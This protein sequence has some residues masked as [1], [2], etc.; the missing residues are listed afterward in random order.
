MLVGSSLA[1]IGSG[2]AYGFYA[3]A[4]SKPNPEDYIAP[5]IIAG[6]IGGLAIIVGGKTAIKGFYASKKENPGSNLPS[7][8]NSQIPQNRNPQRTLD[9]YA[10]EIRNEHGRRVRRIVRRYR[11][12]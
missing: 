4:Q 1:I 8:R 6:A 3:W 11:E 5:E 12:H 9:E 10:E 2:F 7:Q